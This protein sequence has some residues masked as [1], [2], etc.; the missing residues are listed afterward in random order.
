M[1]IWLRLQAEFS[2][3]YW[4]RKSL[5]SQKVFFAANKNTIL[6]KGKEL[7]KSAARCAEKEGNKTS[8]SALFYSILAECLKQKADNIIGIFVHNKL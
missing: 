4:I 7:L 6:D 1:I 8:S 5:I 2:A 3:V